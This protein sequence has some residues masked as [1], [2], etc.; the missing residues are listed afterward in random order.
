VPLDAEDCGAAKHASATTA[1]H[2][3]RRATR[4]LAST[5]AQ[6]PDEIRPMARLEAQDHA[7]VTEFGDNF[8]TPGGAQRW[9]DWLENSYAIV[10]PAGTARGPVNI[11]YG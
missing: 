2:L 8:A 10:E 7:D 4:P 6:R 3:D 11:Q 1:S 5:A 9:G